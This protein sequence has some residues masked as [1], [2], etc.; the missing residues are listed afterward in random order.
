MCTYF[1]PMPPEV[2][3]RLRGPP[4]RAWLECKDLLSF[5][6]TSGVVTLSRLCVSGDRGGCS[7][8]R[9]LK[10]KFYQ[11]TQTM[12]IEGFFPFKEIS[13]H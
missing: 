4:S 10:S 2:I 9:G 7:A 8:R 11:F 13:S 5:G 3:C 1:S 6:L 12:D